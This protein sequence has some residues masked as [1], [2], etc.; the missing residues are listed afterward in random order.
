MT[1]NTFYGAVEGVDTAQHPDNQYV[2]ERPA[3]AQVF[4]RPNAHAPG[5]GHVIVYNWD[6]ADS[7]E[8][9]LSA[10]VPLG[11]TF[12]IR[13]AEDYFGAP[14]LEGTY[15]GG[16]V[17]IPV[18]GAGAL[19]PIGYPGAISATERPGK[20]LAVLVVVSCGG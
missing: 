1:G 11:A 17:T 9:D 5:R 12:T 3:G 4:V 19:D 14:V 7:V 16:S 10:V 18:P 15:S 13:C 20:E 6:L 8:V 2:T